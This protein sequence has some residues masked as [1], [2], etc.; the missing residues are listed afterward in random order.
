[1]KSICVLNLLSNK[2]VQSY[3]GV[4]EEE[5]ALTMEKI[6][7]CCSLCSPVNL[8]ELFSATTTNVTCKIALGRKY[9]EDTNKY[10]RKL[11]SEFTKLLGTPDVGD[12]LPWLA[13]LSHVNG[14]HG[15]AKKV[16]KELD[17]F[18]DGV[19][20]EHMNRH[21]KL[22]ND[23]A[24]I[25]GEDQKDFV[26]A[27]LE[28]QRENTVGFPL[29]KISI[30]ALILD[31]FAAGTHTTYA[32]LEW[33]MTELLRHPKIM[34][35]LQNEVRN[36]SAENSSISE[37][38]LHNMH[39]LK[40]VIKETLRLYP[41]LPLLLPTISTKDVKL[42]GYD[43]IKGARVIINAW[44]IGRDPAS[45]ENP[46]EFLPD[47]FLDNSIDFKGQHFELIP[48]GSGRR[49]CPGILFT[50]AINELLLA[51]LVH[52]FDWSLPSGEK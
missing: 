20:K 49:I 4:R 9:S 6:E 21:E 22:V 31:I 38:D 39:Y 7:K 13:W 48:F 35:K 51:N 25:Q 36:V 50:I 5:T 3:R 40:A 14:L 37:D 45:W 33:A 28:I 30:K 26:D 16:V 34:K 29:E 1:M 24:G 10:F 32:V 8:S 12:Y 18:L 17:E 19:I 42:K 27:L 15:K 46:E 43:I 52:K 44:A 47:R 23:H 11:L 41:S 2:R